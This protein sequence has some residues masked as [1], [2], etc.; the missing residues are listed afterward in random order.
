MSHHEDPR[1]NP[2]LDAA[3]KAHGLKADGP[4]QLSD[5]FRLAWWMRDEMAA[6]SPSAAAPSKEDL[7]NRLN[8]LLDAEVETHK[9][10][11][12][13]DIMAI[14]ANQLLELRK[15]EEAMP[16]ELHCACKSCELA[17]VDE[18][19]VPIDELRWNGEFW[20]CE[21]CWNEDEYGARDAALRLVLPVPKVVLAVK[22]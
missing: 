22:A 6:S 1:N 9:T 20:V 12:Q 14:A 3:L 21:E 7:E 16:K 4:S 15:A 18:M 8:S 10:S 2:E 19:A 11:Y 17:G 13:A 5:A